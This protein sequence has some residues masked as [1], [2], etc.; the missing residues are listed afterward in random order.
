MRILI[1]G[2]FCPQNRVKTI[3]DE[4]KYYEV[5]GGVKDLIHDFDYSIVNFECPIGYGKEKPIAK[6]G[7]NLRCGVSGVKALKYAGF[8]CVT[9][10]NNHFFDYGQEGVEN[11]LAACQLEGIDT[12]G[13]GKNLQEAS[14]TLFK[15]IGERTL[16]V[17]N[18]CEHEYSIATE[19]TGGSNPLNSVNQYYAIKEARKKADY[20]IVIVHGGHEH[21]QLPSTR[22]Q[23]IYRFFIDAG[24][25]AVVNHHQHCYSGYEVYKWKPIFYGLGNFCFDK[26]EKIN[27]EKWTLGYLVEIELTGD[28]V[29]F[30]IQPY[31]QCGDHPMVHMLPND[32]FGE[33]LNELN[34]IIRDDNQL[35]EKTE[36]YYSNSDNDV[37]YLLRPL[38]NHYIRALQ[39]KGLFPMLMPRKWLHQLR[40]YIVCESHRDKVEHFFLNS[41][42]LK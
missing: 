17:I 39:N 12:V 11:T 6:C 25:D 2:D 26:L 23:E 40:N 19:N 42:L 31:Q 1:A 28:R 35:R 7:P 24:A 36:A 30:N 14:T 32:A 29:S 41:D 3:F 34:G 37:Y 33:R 22:M 20:V 9:L 16:A 10:A 27:D 8:N 5:F 38:Q 18:C 21:Y 13:G 4:E 15:K